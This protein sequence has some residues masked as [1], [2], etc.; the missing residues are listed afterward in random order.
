MDASQALRSR[1]AL[2]RDERQVKD[3]VLRMGSLVESQIRAAVR[4]LVARDAAAAGVVVDGDQAVNEAQREVSEAITVAIATQAPVA[5]DLRFLLALDHVAYELE[6]IGDHAA[7]IAKQ[8][9]RLAGA[10]VLREARAL[11]RMGDLAAALLGG[12]LRALVD[13]DDAAARA[14]AAADD[15]IDHA[16]RDVF[17]TVVDRMRTD[18]AFVE[19][20]TRLILATHWLERIGDRATNVAEDVVQLVT[21]RVE[22]LNP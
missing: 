22:D 21:G 20:G 2:D 19:T 18:P 1:G 16:Y 5:R 10:P 14:V 4:A 9:V 13:A 7:S 11:E 3:A 8:A 12:V 6:R 17:A 15:E